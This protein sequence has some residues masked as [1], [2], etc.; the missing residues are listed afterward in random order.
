MIHFRNI[1][2]YARFILKGQTLARILMNETLS[3]EMLRGKVVDVGGGCNPLGF[4]F[5]AT[6]KAD[7]S[8]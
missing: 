6:K 1:M 4:V 7:L 3:R 8:Q 2:R 5:S